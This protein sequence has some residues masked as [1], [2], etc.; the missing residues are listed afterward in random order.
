MRG[1]LATLRFNATSSTLHQGGI[2]VRKL[3]IPVL[4]AALFLAAA[5]PS[6]AGIHYKSTT[7]TEGANGRGGGDIV[8]E[9]WVSGGNAK[10]AFVESSGNPV[11]Q[12]GTYML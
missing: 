9:G 11:A 4:G 12:Q 3:T 6:F 5:V 10:V 8:A 1:L 2:T 7:K